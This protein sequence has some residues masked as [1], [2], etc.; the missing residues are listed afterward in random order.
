MPNVELLQRGHLALTLMYRVLL[1]VRLNLAASWLLALFVVGL[2]L[3][4][5]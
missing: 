3:L 5:F 4:D 2:T 1:A